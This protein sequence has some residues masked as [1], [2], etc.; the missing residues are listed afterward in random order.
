MP[1]PAYVRFGA[2]P[3]A[4]VWVYADS[5]IP[6]DPTCSEIL[7]D[8]LPAS[9]FG[10]VPAVEATCR[11]DDSTIFRFRLIEGPNGALLLARVE[12][13]VLEPAVTPPHTTPII[14]C[15]DVALPVSFDP[16]TAAGIGVCL[17]D[18]LGRGHPHDAILKVWAR[19]PTISP[20][21]T[22]P[23]DVHCWELARYLGGPRGAATFDVPCILN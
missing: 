17:T 8:L 11:I 4:R 21:K 18:P 1:S 22:F 14:E 15:L 20:I 5:R 10:A 7:S 12:L 9:A 19:L 3:Y 13:L 23:D 16:A 6:A 2:D